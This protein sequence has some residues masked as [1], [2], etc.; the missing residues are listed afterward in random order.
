MAVLPAGGREARTD[1]ERLA[2]RDDTTA[3]PLSAVRCTLHTGRTHQ[4][5]VHLASVGHPLL[6]DTTYG[7]RAGG[8]LTRQPLHAVRLGFA[9]PVTCRAMAFEADLP[10][11]FAAAWQLLTNAR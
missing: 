7:G 5:R 8:G 1:V 10:A 11:D 9:H 6:A 3:G 4:I 2:V